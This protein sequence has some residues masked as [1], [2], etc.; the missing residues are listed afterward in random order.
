MEFYFKSK[1][2]KTHLYR[3]SGFIDEDLGE[4]TETF[5]GKLKT[6]NLLGEN[7]ELEDISGFFSKG[8][9]YS[10]KSTKGLS[11]IIEKKS[12]GGRYVLK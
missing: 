7:F 8:N 3:E 9:K 5:T 4:L 1:G 10:I 2:A 12:F 6:Q 11:G